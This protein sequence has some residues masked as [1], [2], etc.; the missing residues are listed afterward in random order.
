MKIAIMASLVAVLL[1]AGVAAAAA[2]SE[3][4]KVG[5]TVRQFVPPPPY[6]WRGAKTHALV[7]AIWYPAAAAAKEVPQRIE[8]PGSPLFEIGRAAPEGQLAPAPDRFP[9]IVLSHGTGGTAQSLGWLGITLAAQGY[10]VAA[11]DHPGNNGIDGYT[12]Q[13][14]TLWWER[15][16]DLSRVI[17]GMLV[18]PLFGPRIDPRR[19]GAA[20]FSLGGYTVIVLAGGITSTVRFRRFCASPQA[21]RMCVAPPEFADL[22]EKAMALARTDP[23]FAAALADDARSYRD[24]R[25]RAVFA[26]AP[27]LGPALTP[28]S[29]AKLAIPIEII[30]GAGDRVAPVT[31]GAKSLAAAIPHATLRL[32][33][34]PTGHYVFTATCT[35][36]GRSA[37]P[38]VCVDPPGVDRDAVHATTADL[39]EA[40]FAR[41][42]GR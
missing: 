31:S 24:A 18:D 36:A 6:D 7:T 17:D 42:L 4:D 12:V 35:T 23:N 26:M 27:A 13:G 25:V 37:R 41:N 30:A 34:A 9:L 11:V 15:A 21:D 1:G 20:G 14:F 10:V 19:I 22:R 3:T 2:G 38:G 5:I 16:R 39:A 8:P 29:L 28:E 40:F 32:L 33:P